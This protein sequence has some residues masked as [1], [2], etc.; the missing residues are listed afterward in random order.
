VKSSVPGQQLI[1]GDVPAGVAK[2]R[3]A[4]TGGKAVT[5][6]P[7]AVGSSRLFAVTVGVNATP[8]RWTSYDAA[9]H[10]TGTA[11]VAPPS[12]AAPTGA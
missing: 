9:G 4:L 8:T 5:A 10:Q 7:V 12:S 6:R 2:V 11:P 3:V 1:I